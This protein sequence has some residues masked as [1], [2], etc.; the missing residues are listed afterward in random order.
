MDHGT[1][2]QS[3]TLVPDAVSGSVRLERPAA[4]S[5]ADVSADQ[6]SARRLR[7]IAECWNALSEVA[8]VFAYAYVV[9]ADGTIAR[10]WATAGF[11]GV[12]GF[13]PEELD[14]AGWENFLHPEDRH[15]VAERTAAV[16][17]GRADQRDYRILT[18]GGEVRWLRDYVGPS[19]RQAGGELRIVGVAQ[20]ITD[21]RQAQDMRAGENRVLRLLAAGESLEELLTATVRVIEE[22]SSDMLCS[23]LLLDEEG[24]HLRHGAAPSLP[25][26][27]NRYVD[28]LAIGPAAGSCGTAA[29]HR[30]RI[31]VADIATD[32]LWA[33][34]QDLPRRYDLKA[35]WSQPIISV[36]G[37]VLG[38]FAMYYRRSR[39]PSEQEVHLIEEAARLTAMV[40][41][42]KRAEHALRESE[43]RF[44]T[45]AEHNRRLVREV[46]HRVRNNLF[47]LLGM[48]ARMEQT[49]TDVPS[50]AAALSGRLQAMAHVHQ[51]LADVAWQPVNMRTLVPSSLA[52]L[53]HLS[54]HAGR[55]ASEGPD[56]YLA[57]QQVQALTL[58]L[59][60]WFTNSCKYG[61]QSVPE[62][63]LT[64]RWETLTGDPTRV[65]LIWTERGGPPACQ[66][67]LPSLGTELVRALVANE[68]RGECTLGF[69][70]DG[71]QHAIEFVRSPAAA[72]TAAE[73]HCATPERDALSGKD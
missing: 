44:R 43:Q 9:A 22:Q 67:G 63:E 36:S 19:P 8:T 10:A 66:P 53:Q 5:Q 7:E 23:V 56:V 47:G 73:Q 30:K 4:I 41:E 38:T 51:L 32:P 16:Q 34:Y 70:A 72:P 45:L 2:L 60:E 55:V 35:C 13:T 20:D 31:I 71:A 50:F 58:V 1:A 61:S 49:S 18:K 46:D 52:N 17:A 42:R 40:I 59:S 21:G 29:H 64:V 65:R 25:E 37:Q 68:L 28:G 12:T 15:I 24:T 62:G 69:T 6:S 27:F 33:N 11:Q 3:T 26:E 39:K 14:A 57:P 54:G 48:I